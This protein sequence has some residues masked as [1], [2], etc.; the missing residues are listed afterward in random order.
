MGFFKKYGFDNVELV[1]A[2][3]DAKTVQAIISGGADVSAMG[4]GTVVSSQQT[5]IPLITVAMTATTLTDS[6]VAGPNIK[7]PADLKG[8]TLAISAFGG[9]S[10][11]AALIGLQVLG[12]T[13]QEVTI[14]QVGGQGARI[15]AVQAGSAAAAVVDVALDEEMKAQGFN[16]LG[17]TTEG[18]REYGRNGMNLRREWFE[19]NPNTVLA[20]TAAV[21]E[22]QNAIWSNT[23]KAIDVFQQ[24]GQIKERSSAENQVRAFM[25]YG[26]RD[27]RWSQDGWELTKEVLA[28]TNPAVA[29]VDV[30]KAYSFE[31]LDKLRDMGMNQMLNIPAS[32]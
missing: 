9:T 22:G 2:E 31:P 11:G 1:F 15:A 24:W 14:T 26:R 6:I 13:P 17:R 30:T 20:L 32:R 29:D 21:I 3:G 27:M 12:L 5:D 25:Q 7:T 18:G 10:H 16:I 28:S 4:V 8:K 23:E 19:K